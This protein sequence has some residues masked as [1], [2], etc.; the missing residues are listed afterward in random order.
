MKE[1]FADWDR[2]VRLDPDNSAVYAARAEAFIKLN[3]VC[4][5]SVSAACVFVVDVVA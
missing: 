4:V 1:A 2:V 3:Q 5:S